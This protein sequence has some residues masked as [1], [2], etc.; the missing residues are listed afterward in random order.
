MN[1]L[2]KLLK[3]CDVNANRLVQ[4]YIERPLMMFGGRKFDIRQWVLVRS[5][6]PLRIFLFSECYLRLCS[7][8]YDLDDLS[9]RERHISNWQVNRYSRTLPVGGCV[10]S[11]D[12]FKVELK[13]VTGSESFW[14][15]KLWPQVCSIVIK[16]LKAV[17]HTLVPRKDSFELYGFDLMVDE[18]MNVWLLEVNL[19][20][21]CEGR[22]PFLDSMMSRMAKRLIDLVVFG[23]ENPDGVHPDWINICNDEAEAGAIR[24]KDILFRA[25]RDLDL[26]LTGQALQAPKKHR[27][28]TSR[29]T[30]PK[31]P[32]TPRKHEGEDEEVRDIAPEPEAFRIDKQLS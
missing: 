6:S 12:D 4:R 32:T 30:P 15:E 19:S 1:S 11:L 3:H 24:S 14:Q 9:S 20:P 17:Q 8:A 7:D 27:C 18:L 28:P 29:R 26:T 21:G 22:A 13:R 10:A 23:E 25:P 2:P 16:T 31:R 5:I